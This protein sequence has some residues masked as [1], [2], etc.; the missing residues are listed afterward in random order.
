MFDFSINIWVIIGF[1]GQLMFFMRF[2]IQ[3]VHSERKKESVIPIHFWYFS[4][5]GGSILLIYAMQRKDLVFTIGQ[6]V[7]LLVYARN[8]ML[9]RNKGKEI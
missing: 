3:W 1:I 9:I 2:F 8:L 5:I 4:I 6:A 7:G